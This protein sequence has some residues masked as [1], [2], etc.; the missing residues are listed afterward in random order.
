MGIL[1]GLL[2]W[3]DPLIDIGTALMNNDQQRDT[4][5]RNVALSREQRAWEER[6][7]NTAIQRRKADIEAA[8]GNPA[9]AFTGGGEASTPN[10]TAPKLD[11]PQ[12]TA[13]GRF[14]EA[15]MTTA[16]LENL[17]ANTGSQVAATA[18][19]GAD[20]KLS[21]ALA[22][23]ARVEQLAILNT[24][25]QSEAQ[26]GMIA[27]Q[28]K[29]I[30]QRIS[31]LISENNLRK[32]EAKLK[33]LTLEDA[34]KVIANQAKTG[35]LGMKAKENENVIQKTIEEVFFNTGRPGPKRW[36]I[37]KGGNAKPQWKPRSHQ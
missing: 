36:D 18:K 21:E 16:Q 25:K 15:R 7:S 30:L 23:K 35:E 12:L 29:E 33:G 3:A 4:N 19:A 22:A 6:M 5:R 26:T 17:R 32:L 8:G 31:N 10:V 1:D 27:D 11:A 13:K 20:T 37:M 24:A 9:L 2:K 34:A 14:N 28:R